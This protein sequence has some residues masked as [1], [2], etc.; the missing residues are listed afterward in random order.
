VSRLARSLAAGSLLA[1]LAGTA[2]A[3]GVDSLCPTRGARCADY[4]ALA[5]AI[6]DELLPVPDGQPRPLVMPS[7]GWSQFG[8]AQ[9]PTP[10]WNPPGPKRVGLQAGHYLFEEAPPELLSLRRNPG[11]PGG[12]R[13]EW[14]V[15]IDL[16][17]RAAE[18][19][20]S[21]GVEV[22]VLPTTI[23]VRYRAH[24]FLA[25]HVDG[26][27]SGRLRGYKIARPN[28]SSIPEVDDAFAQTIHEEYGRATGLPDNSVYIT[29]RMRNY[30]A[31]NA[32]RYQHAVAPGVPQAILESGFMSNGA[33]RD[34][35]FNRPEV[36]AQ[37]IADAVLR[38]LAADIY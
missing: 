35:L 24:A 15:T 22:D 26:D 19:L 36:A 1:L 3:A 2:L 33:D 23:P 16:A 21:S 28:F 27:E 10:V 17:E 13:V 9:P 34:L 4:A 14:Q 25:V 29:G 12:G 18:I 7:G 8:R 11:A 30:Y 31:F 20:R 37:G 32:R 38:F 5:R 6:D